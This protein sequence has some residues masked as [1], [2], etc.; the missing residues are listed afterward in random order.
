MASKGT[1]ASKEADL[2]KDMERY[3]IERLQKEAGVSDAVHAGTCM[4]M[5]WNTGKEVLRDEYLAA[6]KRFKGCAAGRSGHA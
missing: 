6:V 5:D 4:Q 1:G 3:S 2:S